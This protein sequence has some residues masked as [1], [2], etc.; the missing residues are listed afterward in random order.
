MKTECRCQ[1][2]ERMI[3]RA[4]QDIAEL[5]NNAKNMKMIHDAM[6]NTI[7]GFREEVSDL[8][9]TIHLLQEKLRAARKTPAKK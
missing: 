7:D 4:H 2:Y 1:D 8:N 5:K 9:D 6:S 3:V